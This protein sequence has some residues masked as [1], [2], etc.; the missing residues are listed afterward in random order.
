MKKIIILLLFFVFFITV[1]NY[2]V[3]KD[4]YNA[5]LA[6]GYV[7]IRVYDVEYLDLLTDSYIKVYFRASK[8]NDSFVNLRN[9]D[10]KSGLVL[11]RT[12]PI[13]ILYF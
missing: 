4:T 12:N 1:F 2:I 5:L 8:I 3:K 13:K 9:D 7:N 11:Y 6:K 10:I